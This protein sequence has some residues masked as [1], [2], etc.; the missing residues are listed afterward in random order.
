LPLF[1]GFLQQ[2]AVTRLKEKINNYFRNR[3]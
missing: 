1:A 2:K 3:R